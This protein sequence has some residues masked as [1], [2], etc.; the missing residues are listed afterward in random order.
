MTETKR[1][2]VKEYKVVGNDLHVVDVNDKKFIFRNFSV[3][4][5]NTVEFEG[6]G[7]EVE[8]IEF[9]MGGCLSEVDMG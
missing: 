9:E 3:K 5:S 2:H 6:S 8:E 4:K 7:V 1:I